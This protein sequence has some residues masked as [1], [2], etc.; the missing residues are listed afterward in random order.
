MKFL[1]AA[2]AT[3]DRH[4]QPL[5]HSKCGAVTTLLDTHRRPALLYD[6]SRYCL[7]LRALRMLRRVGW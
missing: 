6:R 7:L 5:T 2:F 1:A 3:I 4:C